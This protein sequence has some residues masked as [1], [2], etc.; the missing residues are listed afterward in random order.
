MTRIAMPSIGKN[1]SASYSSS[2][3][4]GTLCPCLPRLLEPARVADVHDEPAGARRNESHIRLLEPGLVH[5][6]PMIRPLLLPERELERALVRGAIVHGL[7]VRDDHVLERELEER[8]E[9]L[10]G[11]LLV[12]RAPDAELA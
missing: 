3:V 4:S 12:R 11:A 2:P 8:A 10:P 7:A 1:V 5:H 6:V 9:R